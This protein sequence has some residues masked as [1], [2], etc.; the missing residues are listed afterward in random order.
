VGV[1][2]VQVVFAVLPVAVLTDVGALLRSVEEEVRRSSEV[3]LSM[4]VVAFTPFVFL[5]N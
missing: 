1:L 4:G 3:L 5:I 2:A